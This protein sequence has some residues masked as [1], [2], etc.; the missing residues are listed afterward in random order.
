[1]LHA[2]FVRSPFAHAR[3]GN[4]DASAALAMPGVGSSAFRI[5]FV[6][7]AVCTTLSMWISNTATTAMMFPIGL[8]IVA[9]MMRTSK[10]QPNLIGIGM[11]EKIVG[12]RISFFQWMAIGVPVVTLLFLY[13]VAQFYWRSVRGLEV[14]A[15]S[16]EDKP[17][18]AARVAWSGAGVNLRSGSPSA[19]RVRRA[20]RQHGIR[21]V[22]ADREGDAPQS[23]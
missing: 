1:M 11:L 2:C 23:Q 5:L 17:E 14:V 21:A 16:T 13:L 3:I 7:G 20:V 19:A 8:S 10:T 18:V 9:H 12:T 22:L 6:Y 15:G 4:I